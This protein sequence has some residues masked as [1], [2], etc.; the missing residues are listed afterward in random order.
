MMTTSRIETGYVYEYPRSSSTKSKQA[1]TET[2]DVHAQDK[3][4]SSC[5][6]TLYS[7]DRANFSPCITHI[8]GGTTYIQAS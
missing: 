5:Y 4:A 3:Q 7:S 6:N 8:K 2:A 1:K